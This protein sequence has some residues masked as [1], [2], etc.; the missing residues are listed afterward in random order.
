MTVSV[1][2]LYICRL[3]KRSLIVDRQGLASQQPRQPFTPQDLVLALWFNGHKCKYRLHW[4][5]WTYFEQY[6]TQGM[7]PSIFPCLDPRSNAATLSTYVLRE[8]INTELNEKNI[9]A[10]T[11]A[12]SSN[13]SSKW[14][15]TAH[16][17]Y[18]IKRGFFN[19]YVNEAPRPERLFH[20]QMRHNWRETEFEAE[21]LCQR[22]WRTLRCTRR[23]RTRLTAC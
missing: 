1:W 17:V 4:C 19:N 13:I 2:F 5:C 3:A 21:K 22:N 23:R 9:A 6:Q 14:F 11:E 10:L 18:Y 7:F 20:R 15:L 12:N 16:H 8:R